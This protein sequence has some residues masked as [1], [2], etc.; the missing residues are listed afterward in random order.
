MFVKSSLAV[1]CDLKAN[2]LELSL[3]QMDPSPYFDLV[4]WQHDTPHSEGSYGPIGVMHKSSLATSPC[5][6]S[7]L[8]FC[9]Y[10][11]TE[12]PETRSD[13]STADTSFVADEC[14]YA[15]EPW[16]MDATD[17]CTAMAAAWHAAY[18]TPVDSWQAWQ[19]TEWRDSQHITEAPKPE[20]LTSSAWDM[21]MAQGHTE[22]LTRSSASHQAGQCKPCAF[23]WKPEGC[24]GGPACNFCHLCP[25]GEKQ[26]RKR[27]LRQM[28]RNAGVC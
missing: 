12:T 7:A 24:Q 6:A 8:P 1:P 25:P 27:V 23:A 9:S 22:P 4:G 20:F 17:T 21:H 10:A 11:Q 19:Q 5:E 18:T 3:W 28:Q 26:R 14:S 16:N 2:D 15:E 13:A